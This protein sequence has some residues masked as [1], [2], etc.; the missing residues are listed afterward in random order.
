MLSGLN[1]AIVLGITSAKIIIIIVM[2]TV[3]A[4]TALSSQILIAITVAIA[5]P[6]VCV[7][8]LPIRITPKSLSVL[9]SNLLTLFADLLFS[10]TKCFSR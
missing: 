3:T 2:K 10:F 7:K 1:A 9:L 6:K 8:L 5:V 4:N